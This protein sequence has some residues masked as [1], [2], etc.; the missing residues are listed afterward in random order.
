MEMMGSAAR[1][2]MYYPTSSS[3]HRLT[4]APDSLPTATKPILGG[5]TYY[6]GGADNPYPA[7]RAS[8]GGLPAHLVSAAAFGLVGAS[9]EYE[10]TYHTG[11]PYY[12]NTTT[13]EERILLV[14]CVCCQYNPCGCEDRFEVSAIRE[15]LN[16]SGIAKIEP[17]NGST[18]VVI[19]G[20]LLNSTTGT[21]SAAG[22]RAPGIANWRETTNWW[23]LA[24]I[25]G[26]MVWGL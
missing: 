19:N 14:Q 7:G 17:V 13:H 3:R 10:Y 21:T 26:A 9:P 18:I 2:G 25:V 11:Y 20:T 12:L 24:T 4:R 5:G 6:P 8:P 16:T 15:M 1:L 22:L 23:V